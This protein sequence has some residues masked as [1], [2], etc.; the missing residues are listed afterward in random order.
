[1]ALWSPG[2][3]LH[4]L[5]CISGYSTTFGIAEVQ[6]QLYFLRYVLSS[7]RNACGADRLDRRDYFLCVCGS[8]NFVQGPAYN[9]DGRRCGQRVA[10]QTALDGAGFRRHFSD[11]FP[12]LQLA[13]ALTAE[14]I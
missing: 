5:W 2:R 4:I 12:A 8:A 3:E 11:C 1:M 10:D 13:K 7:I 9:Q 14:A 6:Q